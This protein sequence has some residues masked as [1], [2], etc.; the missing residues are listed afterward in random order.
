MKQKQH[1][2]AKGER[3]WAEKWFGKHGCEFEY[4]ELRKGER[5]HLKPVPSKELLEKFVAEAKKEGYTFRIFED[6]KGKST[7]RV[8]YFKQTHIYQE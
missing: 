3:E 6:G 5:I 4:R 1:Y 2:F 7:G 8:D